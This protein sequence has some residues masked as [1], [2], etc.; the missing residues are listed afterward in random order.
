MPAWLVP[1]LAGAGA[2]LLGSGLGKGSK[3]GIVTKEVVDPAKQAVA[4]P[5]SSFLASR[6]GT[7]LPRYPGALAPEFGAQETARYNEFL[8]LSAQ[9]LFDKYVAE[10]QTTRFRE[11]FLPILQEGYAGSLRGSG[12]FRS[13]EENINRFS[14]DLA[15]LRYQAAR[16]IPAQQFDMATRMYAI[17]DIKFQREYEDW[18][19]SLAENNPV[20]EKAM[21]FLSE[22]TSSGTTILS[23]LDPGQK[24]WFGD[25]ISALATAGGAYYGARR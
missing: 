13:E 7:G 9:D 10:P 4:S 23:G 18:W 21:Q 3:A 1:A 19:R 11:D 5:L 17:K 8:G 14:Q 22:G 12:R 2:A 24:G 15:G 16:E 6:V 25:I 20:L